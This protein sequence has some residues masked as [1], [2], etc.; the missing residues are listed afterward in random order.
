MSERR[1]QLFGVMGE[2]SSPEELHAK[3]SEALHRW[4]RDHAPA[5]PGASTGGRDP[6]KYLGVLR[7]CVNVAPAAVQGR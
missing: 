4:L 1:S 6:T 5:A 7:G 3:V 2:F